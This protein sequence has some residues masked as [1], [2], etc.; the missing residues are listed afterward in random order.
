MILV[1]LLGNFTLIISLFEIL[2]IP[3]QLVVLKNKLKKTSYLVIH[4]VFGWGWRQVQEF[5]CKL[6]HLG[7]SPSEY[8]QV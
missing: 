8:F 6:G 5:R 2:I 1:T 3:H 4:K 7:A